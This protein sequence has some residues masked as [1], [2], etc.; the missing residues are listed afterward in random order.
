MITDKI[1]AITRIPPEY[2]VPN[3]PCPKSVKVEL[4]GKCNFNCFF[5]AHA[6]G[7]REVDTMDR[8]LYT[9]IITDLYQSGVKELGLFFL[10]E[11]FL[12]PWLHE[13]VKEAKDMGFKYV[14]LTTNG[15]MSTPEKMEACFRA[16]LD[17]LKFSLNYADQE[18][19]EVIARVKGS[20]FDRMVSNIK[21]AREVRDRVW[22]ETG[23]RCGLYGS[24]IQFTDEQ[25]VKMAKMVADISPH[26][27]EVYAL[28]LYN[29]A[30]LVENPDWEFTAGNMGRVGALREPLPCW[31][32][33]TEGHITFDGQLA[34][35][36]FDHHGGFSMGNLS[37]MSFME[38]W[39]SPKFQ[40]LRAAHLTKDVKHTVCE[41]CV[42][43]A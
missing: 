4:T 3:P 11:S 22:A 9:K 21:S 1:D 15:S 20:L 35:C 10:G 12:V 33:F 40:E 37:E 36:C 23:H 42:A 25:A 7:L 27:D 6:H 32:L 31:V 43:W 8:G 17:S 16:G 2:R 41:K 13:A 19:F 29:Q 30:A 34:A 14:F 28:P 18:Q 39:N 26:L 5:C 24:Y 38:A